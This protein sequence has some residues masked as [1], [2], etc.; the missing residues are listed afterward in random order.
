MNWFY[1]QHCSTC[2]LELADNENCV[3]HYCNP[4]PTILSE[5]TLD[6]DCVPVSCTIILVLTLAG[7]FWALCRLLTEASSWTEVQEMSQDGVN[8]NVDLLVGDI[9]G[10]EE[11]KYDRLG[12]NKLIIASRYES[13]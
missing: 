3:R 4:F 7:T 1:I 2:P 13:F 9:Y 12:L 8:E 10:E 11:D 5:T 6:L